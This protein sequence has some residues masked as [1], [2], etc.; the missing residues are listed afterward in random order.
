MPEFDAQ[1]VGTMDLRAVLATLPDKLRRR[2]ARNA[3]AAGARIVRDEAKANA[4]VLKIPTAYRSSGTVRDAIKVRTSKQAKA[5]GDVGVYV[6]VKPLKGKQIAA[7]KAS[8]GQ[9]AAKNPTDPFYWRWLEFGRQGRAGQA[10]RPAKGGI[11]GLIRP[12]RARRA[13]A[14]VGPMPAY[15]FLQKGAGKLLDA[16]R[17][18]EKVLGPMVE[19]LNNKGQEP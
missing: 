18:I 11:R 19:K 16:L 13:L 3:L 7:F 8:T 17:E 1:V 10:A 14:A 5:N 12:V 9:A 2:A 4:P 6:N 15:R